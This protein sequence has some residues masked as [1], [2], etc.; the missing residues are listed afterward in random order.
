[1]HWQRRLSRLELGVYAVVVAIVVAVFLERATYYLELAERSA[2][3][4][5]V[6][7]VNTGLRLRMAAHI[8][9]GTPSGGRP[10]S[11]DP[12]VFAGVAAPPN[13]R[14]AADESSAALSGSWTYDGGSGELIY[15]PRIGR[16]L[17]T[18]HADGSIRFRLVPAQTG[19]TLAATGA[20]TW[21]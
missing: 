12:F 14:G 3:E 15:R 9:G 7:R 2:M 4:V 8:I 5:T 11:A 13:Y 16:F 1:M 20:Y 10:E 17:A 21:W 18:S 19:W 6:Q